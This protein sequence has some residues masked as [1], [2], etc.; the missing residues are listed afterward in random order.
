MER[1][2]ELVLKRSEFEFQL[3]Y[4]LG[5]QPWVNHFASLNLNVSI[6]KIILIILLSVFE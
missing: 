1:V 2:H 6:R 4:I 5:V 3:S